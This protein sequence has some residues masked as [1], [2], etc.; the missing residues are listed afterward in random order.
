M[1]ALIGQEKWQ[2]AIDDTLCE[3]KLKC[4]KA[5]NLLPLQPFPVS[6]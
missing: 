4:R 3:Q 5:E 6:D 2:I 1:S